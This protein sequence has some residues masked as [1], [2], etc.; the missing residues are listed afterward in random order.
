MRADEELRARY[1]AEGYVAPLP[2]LAPAE[3]AAVRARVTPLLD[4]HGR[5]DA[6]LR[7]NP[8]LLFRWADVLIDDPRLLAPVTALLGPD[9]L[10]RD[11]VLFAKGP[12]DPNPVYWHQ[13]AAHWDLDGERLATVWL[14]FTDS[15]A[16]N[17][18]VRVV[19]GSHRGPRLPHVL[20]RDHAGRLIRS[21]VCAPIDEQ[22]AVDLTL[23]AG[24]L[25]THHPWLLHGSPPNPGRSPRIGLAIRYVAP[26]VRERAPFAA[27]TLVAG[28]CDAPHWRL[29]PRPRLDGDARCADWHRR[30]LRRYALHVAWQIARRPSADHL[31]LLGHLA[32][33][34]LGRG[35]LGRS[36]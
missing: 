5:A 21:R 7:N 36:A 8:H 31:R 3:A 9:V 25:S 19:P 15:D 17:G 2:G 13:D 12:H 14:A 27:A 20:G 11:T 35:L 16:G 32:R 18:A 23:R 10:V 29:R 4:A 6:M 1:A 30:A 26:Q 33:R 22:A 24:E 28:R 34:E